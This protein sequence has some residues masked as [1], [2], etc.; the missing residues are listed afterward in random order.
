MIETQTGTICPAEI[1][2]GGTGAETSGEQQ[3]FVAKKEPYVLAVNL[4]ERICDSA[5]LNQ[6]YKRVKAN[7]GS[8]GIDGMTVD[9]LR[10]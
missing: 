6:A 1:S 4:M 8:A 3:I 10:D 2:E 5:N 9:D 7:K